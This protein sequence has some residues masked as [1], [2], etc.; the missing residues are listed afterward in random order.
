MVRSQPA[1]LLQQG[2]S[3]RGGVH[4]PPAERAGKLFDI[5]PESGSSHH[6]I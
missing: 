5:C 3:F 1:L 6:V 4:E 2:P